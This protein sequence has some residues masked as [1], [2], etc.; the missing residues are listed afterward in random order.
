MRILIV[1][2]AAPAQDQH[3]ALRPEVC[4]NAVVSNVSSYILASH[5]RSHSAKRE[6]A[7][8]NCF[9]TSSAVANLS[10]EPVVD[11][12]LELRS[13]KR[14][15][16]L[17]KRNETPTGWRRKGNSPGDIVARRKRR[18]IHCR[19]KLG[20][21]Q[22]FQHQVPFLEPQAFRSSRSRLPSV[23]LVTSLPQSAPSTTSHT[24][25]NCAKPSPIPGR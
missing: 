23:S 10:T 1:C 20:R 7:T 22:G 8:A 13:P 4:D 2:G 18:R 3:V 19:N 24:S 6:E 12:T 25:N 9:K 21:F 14:A 17:H 15:S 16:V 11:H 5:Q